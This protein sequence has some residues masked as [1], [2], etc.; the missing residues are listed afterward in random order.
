MGPLALLLCC[1]AL[2]AAHPELRASTPV[3]AGPFFDARDRSPE[4]RGGSPSPPRAARRFGVYPKYLPEPERSAIPHWRLKGPH[5]S[6]PTMYVPQV[7]VEMLVTG[8]RVAN[9]VSCSAAQGLNLIRVRRDDE[10]LAELLHFLRKFWGAVRRQQRPTDDLFWAG[11]GGGGGGGGGEEEEEVRRYERFL[12]RTR[13]LSENT[14]VAR[15]IARPWRRSAGPDAR[16]FFL[17]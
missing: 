11:V 8:A 3:P 1:A 17:D 12:R 10:Y 2:L 15:H 5:E 14:K 7:Q 16:R 13:A 4:R 9:Y 6:V